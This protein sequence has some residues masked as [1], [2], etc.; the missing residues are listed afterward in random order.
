MKKRKCKVCKVRFKITKKCVYIAKERPVF[1][2]LAKAA[3]V[4]TFDVIDCPSCGCQV[5][6]GERLLGIR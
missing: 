3:S 2:V 4:K 5:V 1:S 6:L